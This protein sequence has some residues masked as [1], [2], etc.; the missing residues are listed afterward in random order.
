MRAS[1]L[2]QS[3]TD[4]APIPA[5]VPAPAPIIAAPAP[6][7]EPTTVATPVIYPSW[8]QADPAQAP[9]PV[10]TFV[11]NAVAPIPVVEVVPSAEV[12]SAPVAAAMSVAPTFAA[13][14]F[15]NM[16]DSGFLEA[17]QLTTGGA[18]PWYDAALVTQ[19]YNGTPDAAQRADF[20]NTVL[21]RVESTYALS[22]MPVKLTDDPNVS[23]AHTLSVVSNTSYSTNPNAIGITD[24][25]NN[26]FSFIDKLVYAK[27]VDELEW[28]VAHNVAHE[29][30]HAFDVDHHDTTGQFLDAAVTPWN[31][32]VDPNTVFGPAAVN[33]LMSQDFQKR[34]G[35]ASAYGPQQLTDEGHTII[36]PVPEPTTIALWS[37]C[38]G[39][40]V[41]AR[42]RKSRRLAA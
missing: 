16:G 34:W 31:V 13:D 18:E 10:T 12:A 6:V 15:V 32:L 27:S 37:G 19:L 20:E 38:L 8:W 26:G 9:T 39:L 28:A 35:S 22:G 23:A 5:A 40:L 1:D 14:A 7:P 25:G 4:P 21:Q 36:S 2:N 29:L 24:M 30:M 42:S 41:F 33:D 17:S 3:D 11:S